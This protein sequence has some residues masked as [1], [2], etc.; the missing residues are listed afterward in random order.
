MV[1]TVVDGILYY[2]LPVSE[3]DRGHPDCVNWDVSCEASLDPTKTEMTGTCEGIVCGPDG[4]QFM[5]VTNTA[6]KV[7]D[8]EC[9]FSEEDGQCIYDCQQQQILDKI[10][11]MKDNPLC[12]D[13]LWG[14]YRGC[15]TA[16]L[17]CSVSC[18]GI[19]VD[20]L[21]LYVIAGACGIVECLMNYN[22]GHCLDDCID[23]C[24]TVACAETCLSNCYPDFWDC[25][26]PSI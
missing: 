24:T 26:L 15:D 6:Y 3:Q 25:A 1:G 22:P 13:D 4:G 11:C 5:S 10:Q 23:S 19:E 2:D 14:C 12:E 21:Y 9:P 7:N 8:G 16:T 17:D 18:T 20:E